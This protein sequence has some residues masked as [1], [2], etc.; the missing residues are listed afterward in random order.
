MKWVD[1]LQAMSTRLLVHSEARY[2]RLGHHSSHCLDRPAR[3]GRRSR[4]KLLKPNGLY[5]ALPINSQ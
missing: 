1:A 5:A 3:L 2:Q 4:Q